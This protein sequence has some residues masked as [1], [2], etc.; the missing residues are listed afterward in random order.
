MILTRL[1]E[2]Y[3]RLEVEQRVASAG[4]Q[5]KGIPFL[6]V[7]DAQGRFIGL[8]DTRSGDG[9]AR[10]ATTFLVPREVKRSAASK[11]NLFWDNPEYVFGMA[12]EASAKGISRAQE[13]HRLFMERIAQLPGEVRRDPGVSAVGGRV[14]IGSFLR[15]TPSEPGG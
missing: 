2:H 13:R 8:Q 3:Q 14:S 5:Q 4:F 12:S 1:F 15:G 10:H 7:L 11:A 6:V 9:R